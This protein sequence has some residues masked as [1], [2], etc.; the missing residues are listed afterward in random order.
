MKTMAYEPMEY[1][2]QSRLEPAHLRPI[3]FQQG[4]TAIG[5]ETSQRDTRCWA[6]GHPHAREPGCVLTST[7]YGISLSEDQTQV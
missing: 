1:E 3:D 2:R 7:A 6:R 4:A 5:R